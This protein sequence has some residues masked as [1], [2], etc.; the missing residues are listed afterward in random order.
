M[1]GCVLEIMMLENV[2]WFFQFRQKL[3]AVHY[4]HRIQLNKYAA[5]KHLD[6][7]DTMP[8]KWTQQKNISKRPLHEKA[9][10]PRKNMMHNTNIT[11]LVR[12]DEPKYLS[13]AK[14]PSA[15]KHPSDQTG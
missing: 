9:R 13:A 4:S 7:T 11:F 14:C 8:R 1:C 3:V 15:A 10:P 6:V 12:H 5:A 2:K